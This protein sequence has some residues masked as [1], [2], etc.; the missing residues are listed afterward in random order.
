MTALA[1]TRLNLSRSCKQYSYFVCE[2]A[3]V[4]SIQK[5]SSWLEIR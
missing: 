5:S 2:C 1:Q 4:L 3:L